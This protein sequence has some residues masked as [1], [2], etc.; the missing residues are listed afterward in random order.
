MADQNADVDAL[1]L[2]AGRYLAQDKL[3][4]AELTINK[5]LAIDKKNIKAM[6]NLAMILGRLGR[7]SEA[8]ALAAKVEARSK[9]APGATAARIQLMNYDPDC[10]AAEALALVM[11][12]WHPRGK[13]KP[14]RLKRHKPDRAAAEQKTLRVGYVSA[15]LFDHPVGS[16]LL[17]VL[18]AHDQEKITVCIYADNVKRDHVTEALKAH[19]AVWRDTMGMSTDDLITLIENDRIDILVDLAGHTIG[20]RLPVFLNKPAPVQVSWLGYCGSTGLKSMDYCVVD[21]HVVQPGEEKHY[22]E[23]VLR[24][25]HALMCYHGDED[26]PDVAPPPSL[27]SESV[28]FGSFNNPSKYSP[29]VI[30]LWARLLDSVPNSRLLLKY[31]TLSDPSAAQSVKDSFA[32]EGVDPE[33]IT[34]LGRT[35]TDA[36]RNAYGGVDIALDPFPYNGTMTTLDA[37]WM[38]VPVITLDGDRWVARMTASILRTIGMPHLIAES[39]DRYIEIAAELSSDK[40][41]LARLRQEMR[42]AIQS[43]PL[44]DASGFTTALETHYAEIWNR[45]CV[46]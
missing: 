22:T 2:E 14:W 4:Q 32:A 34:T 38:G 21:G 33:K 6:G 11:S 10:D 18:A 1:I 12:L 3:Q 35:A 45:W 27:E 8:T 25:P 15:D 40:A 43:S 42:A 28:V 41:Q 5:A 26:A 19:S 36:H 23:R 39:A 46:S 30:R 44:S 7:I 16:L 9:R 13:I 29:Q 37:L 20:N 31:R 24:M 17:P